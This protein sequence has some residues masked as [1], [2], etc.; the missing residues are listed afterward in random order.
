MA[1]P[2][3]FAEAMVLQSVKQLAFEQAGTYVESYTK[4]KNFDLTNEDIQTIAD[5]AL[6]VEILEKKRSLV[7]EGL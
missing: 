3:S 2:P 6:Q 1:K 5:G 4:V 7:G